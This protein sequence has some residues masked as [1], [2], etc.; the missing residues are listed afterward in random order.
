MLRTRGSCS[1]PVE[2]LL[3]SADYLWAWL[4]YMD[5]LEFVFPRAWLFGRLGCALTHDHP[6]IP[7]GVWLGVRYPE[8]ARYAVRLLEVLFTLGYLGVLMVLDGRQWPAGFYLGLFLST[9]GLFRLFLDRL[10]EA[11][12]RYWG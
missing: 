2:A 1:E 12:V 11:P 8:G 10:H 9:Y 7:D 5:A 3:P 6:G 4:L